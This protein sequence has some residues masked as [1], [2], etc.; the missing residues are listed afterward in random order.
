[1]QHEL[2]TGTVTFL[3]TDVEGSTK[4]LHELGAEEYS[5]ALAE[6]RRIL[7][8]AFAANEGV[9]VDTQGDAFFV[10]FPTAPGALGGRRRSARRPGRG[11]DP[12]ADG[13]PY[14]DAAPGRGRLRRDRRA[15]GGAD[16][17]LWPRR[18]GAGLGLDRCACGHGRVARPG[19]APAEGP[20]GAGADLPARGRRLPAAE[21]PAPNEPAHPCDAVPRPR[22][23]AGR[24]ARAGFA[25]RRPPADADRPGRHRQ[26]APRVA[27]SRGGVGRAIPAVSSGF[28]SL[29]CATL[30]S[31]SRRRRRRSGRG[32]DW[33]STSAT[34]RCCCSSTT[35]ST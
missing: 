7:R 24:C 20:V 11:A 16:R 1:M 13:H 26:D 6:H 22:A 29:R 35:S 2:P 21:E 3:F 10:A 8:E 27:G 4:L 34:R 30:R 32:T 18:A 15:P 19:R 23:G 33:P 25:G 14:G 17:C 12:G 28:R 31:C 5:R 9:E